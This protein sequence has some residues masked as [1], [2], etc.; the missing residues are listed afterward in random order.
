MRF[1]S[2]LIALLYL[3]PA[4]G[5][6]NQSTCV[7]A[8]CGASATVAFKIV[9]PPRPLSTRLLPVSVARYD[10]KN[11]VSKNADGAIRPDETGYVLSKNDERRFYTV[12]KP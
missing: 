10:E 12:A 8:G 4:W 6:A 2:L 5:S 11:P 3:W 9:I 7:G 1:V